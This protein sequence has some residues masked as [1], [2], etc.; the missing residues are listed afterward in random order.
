MASPDPSPAETAPPGAAPA[1]HGVRVHVATIDTAAATELCI[2]TLH[3]HAGHPFELVVGDGGSTDGSI[4]MLRRFERE[5]WLTLQIAE[6][7]RRHAE[8]L[9]LWMAEC[10]ARYAVFVDS[11]MEFRRT[12]WLADLVATAERTGAAMVTSR[13]QTLDDKGH[14]GS[15]GAPW[16]WAPRP[17]P[18]L[19]LVDLAQVHGVVETG[20]GFRLRPDPARDGGKIAYDTGAAFLEALDRHGL[21]WAAMPDGW[22]DCYHHYGGMTWVRHNKLTLARRLKVKGKEW[23]VWVRCRLARRR[24]PAPYRP[25]NDP[26]TSELSPRR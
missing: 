14:V 12:G 1:R 4:P 26:R 8:W 18:W 6:G 15:D 9:N 20:W 2:R 21:A 13:I 23:Q 5:G 24:A 10:P 19:I 22:S 11:D 7:G 17:T 16:R 25:T 3:R